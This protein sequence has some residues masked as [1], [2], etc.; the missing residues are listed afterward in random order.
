MHEL[1]DGELVK[2]GALDEVKTGVV[3]EVIEVSQPAGRQ[4]VEGHDEIT[5]RQQPLDQM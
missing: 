3:A 5:A 1:V 4:I 2:H